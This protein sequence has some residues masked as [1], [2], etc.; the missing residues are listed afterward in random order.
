MLL[1][2]A[3]K[4][5]PFQQGY[6]LVAKANRLVAESRFALFYP[7]KNKDNFLD[8]ANKAAFQKNLASLKFR[9]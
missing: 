3:N 2:E 6:L 9:L 1:L 5:Y 8:F 4:T 7:S